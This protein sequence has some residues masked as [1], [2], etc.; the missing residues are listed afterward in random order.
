MRVRG[1]GL[2][3][4]DQ[5]ISERIT[6]LAFHDIGFGF[7]VGKRNGGYLRMPHAQQMHRNTDDTHTHTHTQGAR[8]MIARTNTRKC[9][10]TAYGVECMGCC[11]LMASFNDCFA[12]FQFSFCVRLIGWFDF[13][14]QPH[15][16][17]CTGTARKQGTIKSTGAT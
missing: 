9:A 11:G 14:T 7:L 5:F 4:V 16:H 17:T 1:D 10:R 2:P 6:G 15:I 3:F 12:I 8:R 13:L